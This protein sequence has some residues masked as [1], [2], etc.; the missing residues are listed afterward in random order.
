[1]CWEHLEDPPGLGPRLCGV[2]NA[3]SIPSPAACRL[4]LSA[5]RLTHGQSEK[6]CLLIVE[7]PEAACHWMLDRKAHVLNPVV[8]SFSKLL[9]QNAT[10]STLL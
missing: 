2:C 1:M 7:W 4:V 10:G 3:L 8:R 6:L 9:A 5:D